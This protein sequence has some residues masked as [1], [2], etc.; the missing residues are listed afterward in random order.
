MIIM[1]MNILTLIIIMTM[2]LH[3]DGVVSKVRALPPEK[4][5]RGDMNSIGNILQFLLDSRQKCT[6]VDSIN[7][8][9]CSY[10]QTKHV[11][12]NYDGTI[13]TTREVIPYIDLT[14]VNGTHFTFTNVDIALINQKKYCETI[15]SMSDHIRLHLENDG[16]LIDEI[17]SPSIM[18][19]YTEIISFTMSQAHCTYYVPIERLKYSIVSDFIEL[20]DGEKFFLVGCIYYVGRHFVLKYRIPEND[21]TIMFYDDTRNKGYATKAKQ[22]GSFTWYNNEF[23]GQNGP[24]FEAIYIKLSSLTD[25]M[26]IKINNMMRVV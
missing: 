20:G 7:L 11:V 21:S 6:N 3:D 4:I 24:L 16:Y 2:I 12:I 5:K 17:S 9:K 10:Q 14:N 1:K 19:I 25:E 22:E 15:H 8:K 26:Q 18:H 13:R 23:S